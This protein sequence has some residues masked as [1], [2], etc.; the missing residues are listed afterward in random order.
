MTPQNR[1]RLGLVLIVMQAF[2]GPQWALLATRPRLFLSVCIAYLTAALLLIIAR[3]LQWQ[4]LRIVAF[5]NS[6]VDAAAIGSILYAS[7]GVTSGLGI[8]LVRRRLRPSPQQRR[9]CRW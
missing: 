6:G 3:R 2:A 7:G 1:K 4:S 8:L 9:R 5:I